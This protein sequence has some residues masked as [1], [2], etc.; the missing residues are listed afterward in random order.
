M[1]EGGAQVAATEPAGE[2]PATP[3]AESKPSRRRW[4]T[5]PKAA[6]LAEAPLSQPNL[7]SHPLRPLPEP[8]PLKR[9]QP[10]QAEEP[11]PA[12]GAP[13]AQAVLATAA[14][15]PVAAQESAVEEEEEEEAAWGLAPGPRFSW[16]RRQ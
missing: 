8:K 13:D 12:V 5:K 7:P 6:E 9:L 1:Q 4:A 14:P 11:A 10:G 16:N 2:T 15:A 3:A